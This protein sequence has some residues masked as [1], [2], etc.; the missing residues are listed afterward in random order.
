VVDGIGRELGLAITLENGCRRWR[1]RLQ[2]ME[3][4][5]A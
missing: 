2:V 1:L 4:K 3:L 5:S